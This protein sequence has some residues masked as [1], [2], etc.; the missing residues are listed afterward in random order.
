M[1]GLC[2][3]F[4]YLEI[5]GPNVQIPVMETRVVGTAR[6]RC[7]VHV[8]ARSYH[9]LK[10]WFLSIYYC[11]FLVY[12]DTDDHG[13]VSILEISTYLSL[14]SRSAIKNSVEAPFTRMTYARK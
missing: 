14:W 9:A 10:M 12:A 2:P 7:R 13:T 1:V 4:Q 6:L 11:V 3:W 5:G 8:L